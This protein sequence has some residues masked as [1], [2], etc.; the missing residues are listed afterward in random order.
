MTQAHI[1]KINL[2]QA[3][4][5]W[6]LFGVVDKNN[7]PTIEHVRRVANA[8]QF[9][10]PDQYFAA[11]LHD[12]IEDCEGVIYPTELHAAIEKLFGKKTLA[13]VLSLTHNKICES[14]EEYIERLARNRLAIPVKLA[15][16]ADNMDP[17]RGEF[18]GRDRLLARYEKAKA[19]LEQKL[20]EVPPCA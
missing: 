1:L 16:L 2:A 18:P 14:Y 17:A 12:S 7:R 9:L 13:I 8:C 3:L 10:S 5:E 4:A 19:Y 15:D 20:A 11:I 6:S